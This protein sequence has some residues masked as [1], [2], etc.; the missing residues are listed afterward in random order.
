VSKTSPPAGASALRTHLER[1]KDLRGKDAA[2]GLSGRLAEVKRWQQAR[3]R[4][5][6]ADFAALPRYR[7][8]TEFFLDDLYGAKDFSGRDEA[9]LKIHP[10]MVRVLP[11]SAVETAALAIELDALSEELDRALAR[12]L[13]AGPITEESYAQAYRESASPPMRERQIE[14]VGEVGRRLDQ[15]VEKPLVFQTLKLMRT[16]ARLAGLSDLQRFLERGFEAFRAMGGADEF[17]EE[18][19]LRERAIAAKL[20]SSRQATSSK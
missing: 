3:L 9:M 14:L 13:A 12:V 20:F 15:L 5:T 19:A 8:A 2:E 1:L 17:L 10:M 4:R 16:P 11:A 18:I 6:H 7:G